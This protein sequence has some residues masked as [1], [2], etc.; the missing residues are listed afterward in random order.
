MLILR[1]DG[2]LFFANAHDFVTATRR[3]IDKTEPAPKVILFDGE[4][5]N[6]DATA[7][8][9]L[10]EFA[11]QL[12]DMGVRLRFAQIKTSVMEVMERWL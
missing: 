2:S 4:S 3:V 11:D 12:L 5:M 7:V 1:F 9:T 6:I 10:K 8:I